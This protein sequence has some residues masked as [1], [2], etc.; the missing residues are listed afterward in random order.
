MKKD[1]FERARKPKEFT[2]V[3]I[4]MIETM[5]GLVAATENLMDSYRSVVGTPS[6]GLS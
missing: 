2:A 1:R 5:Q 4:L 3:L 6:F